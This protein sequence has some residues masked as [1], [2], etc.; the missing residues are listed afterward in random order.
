MNFQ[1]FFVL[2]PFIY[3]HLIQLK[4]IC[5]FNLLKFLFSFAL[6]AAASLMRKH[7]S[8]V[9]T[10]ISRDRVEPQPQSGANGGVIAGIVVMMMML[11]IPKKA[12]HDL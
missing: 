12:M 10:N 8:D 4:L 1:L 11:M 3:L 2:F 5:F 7:S 9:N 6:R